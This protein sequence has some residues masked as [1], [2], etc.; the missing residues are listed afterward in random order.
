MGRGE[1]E[2]TGRKERGGE[3]IEKMGEKGEKGERKGER[4]RREK[5]RGRFETEGGEGRQRGRWEKRHPFPPS[6]LHSEDTHL[7]H[8][9][10]A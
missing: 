8:A 6:F 10:D 9:H 5:E 7:M 2:K 3:K 1:R 4:S